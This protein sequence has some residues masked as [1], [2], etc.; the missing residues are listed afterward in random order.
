MFELTTGELVFLSVVG[1]FTVC[2]WL[3]FVAYI[4]GWI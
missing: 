3:V 4:K 1:T 2:F